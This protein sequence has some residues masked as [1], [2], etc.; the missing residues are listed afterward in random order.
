MD[1]SGVCSYCRSV[2]AEPR[3]H[4]DVLAERRGELDRIAEEVRRD[5]RG[6]AYDCI[7]PLSGGK[8][9]AYVLYVVRRVL[10]LRA[11]GLN[12]HNGL[13]AESARRN[14]DVLCEDLDVP[15][16]VLRPPWSL[17]RGLYGRFL[18]EAGEFCSACNGMG[19]LLIFSFALR[20]AART[21][22]HVH[23]FG[24]WSARYDAEPGVYAFD[25]AYMEEVAG[26]TLMR[27]VLAC[28][29]VDPDCA[30]AL[31]AIPDPREG[32]SA[33]RLAASPLRYYMLPDFLPWFGPDIRR[34]LQAE[35]RWRAPD[36]ALHFDCRGVPFGSWIER[37]KY[38]FNQA[39]ITHSAWIRDGLMDREQALAALAA[40]RRDEP[41]GL[42]D[43]LAALGLTREGVAWDGLWQPQRR[44]RESGSARR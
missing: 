8:D 36:E 42:D 4:R 6:A 39:E 16:V 29:L 41:A 7:V 9:S 32:A 27:E 43:F 5:G 31:R 33:A 17:M 37:R 23:G 15:L 30:D 24:G 19:Y 40:E 21:G 3:S 38:G 12:F 11:L 1:D 35:T 44:A 14:L 13:Q 34:L 20:E 22:R 25:V 2:E 28:P 26:P 10:G 18:R